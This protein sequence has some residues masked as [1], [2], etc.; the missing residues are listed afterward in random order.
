[1]QPS[2]FYE[3][4][5]EKDVDGRD[6]PGHDG[7][8]I[9]FKLLESIENARCIFG[10]LSGDRNLYVPLARQRPYRPRYHPRGQGCAAGLA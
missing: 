8:R 2:T 5:R 4:S 1:M 10:Q 7:K 3:V 6:E 9:V